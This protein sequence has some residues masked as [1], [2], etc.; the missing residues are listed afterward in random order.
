MKTAVIIAAAGASTHMGAAESKIW[1]P[2]AGRPAL[3]WSLRRFAA[4]AAVTQIIV[5]FAAAD[6]ARGRDF[7]A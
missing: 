2:L 3:Y 4:D 6:L 1:L 7:L 5:A